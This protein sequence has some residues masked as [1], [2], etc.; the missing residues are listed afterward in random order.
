M[1][2][3]QDL[4]SELQELHVFHDPATGLRA[5]IAVD[6]ST[7]GPP[8]GGTRLRRYPDLLDG[9]R[10]AAR[11]ARGMTH[12]FAV[13]G[14]PF[15]GGKAVILQ[16][17]AGEDRA[18]LEA[19]LRA[20]GRCLERLGGFFATGPDFGIGGKEVAVI[21][22]VTS[23][24]LG[25]HGSNAGEATAAGVRAALELALAQGGL[26]LKGARIA[27]SGVGAV[28]GAL[29]RQLAERGARL[30]VADTNQTRVQD[31]AHEIKAEV[32]DPDAILFTEVDALAPCA[33]GE[34][35]TL[36]SVARLRCK[37]V[38]GAANDQ[39]VDA[40]RTSS[41]LAARGILFVPDFV[42][43]GGAAVTLSAKLQGGEEAEV[44]VGEAR[45]RATTREVLERA[46]RE[47]ITPYAAALA[48]SGEARGRG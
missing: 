43:N 24:A 25:E 10:E 11:L 13:H 32:V 8:R 22:E 48:M 15:G 6:D 26:E 5:V 39:L 37:V 14:I 33:V 16:D 47:A 28:G 29:A 42:A 17:D 7:L 35:F 38:A 46:L 30:L 34:L 12:K 2:G 44:A 41:A 27:V 18:V 3:L 19:R 1:S 21:Q 45:I 40:D 31:L 20:Y 23:L 4:A 36:E 9:A